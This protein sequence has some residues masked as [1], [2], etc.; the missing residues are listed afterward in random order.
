MLTYKK[1]TSTS[2]KSFK[3]GKTYLT[4]L[5]IAV[6]TIVYVIVSSL[7]L[8]SFNYQLNEILNNFIDYFTTTEEMITSATLSGYLAQ[9]VDVF[10]NNLHYIIIDIIISLVASIISSILTFIAYYV[11]Y[12][13]VNKQSSNVKELLSNLWGG[14]VLTL[15]YLIKILLWSL[16]FIIP[17]II[18]TF[19]YAL[20][21]VIKIENPKMKAKECIKKS[22]ELMNGRKERLFIQYLIFSLLVLLGSFIVSNVT[23]LISFVPEFGTIVTGII[24]AFFNGV[25]TFIWASMVCVYY[26]GVK[27][28][29]EYISAHPELKKMGING[30]LKDEKP[31]IRIEYGPYNRV[32]DP[33]KEEVKLKD[34]YQNN[35]FKNDQKGESKDPYED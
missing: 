5:I 4:S 10:I 21:F 22:V 11:A 24:N 19:S 7:L 35:P 12:D 30:V 9:I 34:P 25:T 2:L 26:N 16:L 29:E 15:L 13:I 33:F 17:G 28:D 18:K 6:P 32:Q 1:I 8:S 14:I 23:M 31:K 27:E 20:C 3:S